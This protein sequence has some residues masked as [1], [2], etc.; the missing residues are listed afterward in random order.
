[1]ALVQALVQASVDQQ[2]V[3]STFP[4]LFNVDAAVGD[5]LDKIGEWVGVS[6]DLS[7]ALDITTFTSNQLAV[8]T[9][10]RVNENPLN[11]ANW[12]VAF[13]G[14]GA[15]IDPLQV[16]SEACVPSVLNTECAEFYSGI[17]TPNDQYAEV[18]LGP[19]TPGTPGPI[20]FVRGNDFSD[21][22]FLEI[23]QLSD[24][25][26]LTQLG[27]Q[28]D[29]GLVA[30]ILGTYGGKISAGDVV[31]LSATGSTVTA[32]LNG[33]TIIQAVDANLTVGYC[34]IDLASVGSISE[35][36]VTKFAMGGFTPS[37]EQI[38][39]LNDT[40]FRT[41]IK[42]FIA[43]NAWDGTVPD[44]YTIWDTVFAA[45]GLKIL[46]QDNQDMTMTVVFLN[47]PIDIVVL[48][49][50]TQG[51]FLLRPAGV[52]ITGFF[53]PSFPTSQVPIFG[54]DVESAVIAGFDVG[55]W[56]IEIVA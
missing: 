4:A 2:F 48:A 38:I 30:V 47:P 14:V 17:A 19:F 12:S 50:L 8:D 22:Y 23:D 24:G 32:T 34:G 16:L 6:R 11:P 44:M 42:L 21:G 46:V 55:A 40:Q 20:I 51:F 53:E 52:M 39:S 56:M 45:E 7:A 54:F 1:M 9:F 18:T 15:G 41:L 10:Q 37:V 33:V 3:L 28:A 25:S 5:Q 36:S 35:C 29:E 43:M 27:V 26:F 13:G 31:R 49:I